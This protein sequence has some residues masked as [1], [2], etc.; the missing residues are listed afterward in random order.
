[1]TG[2]WIV[3]NKAVFV[4][5]LV[6]DYCQVSA[7]INEQ[8]R[9]FVTSGTVSYAVVRDLLGESMRKG[10]FWRLKDTAHYL[11]RAAAT[12]PESG[13]ISPTDDSISLW[14]FSSGK[15]PDGMVQQSAVEAALDWIIGYAFHECVKLKEDAFQHQHY[16]NRLLQMLRADQEDEESRADSPENSSIA[17]QINT[18][19]PPLLPL[20]RQTLT[21]IDRELTRILEVLEYGRSLLI[22]HLRQHCHNRHLARLLVTQEELIRSAFGPQ[23]EG[24]LTALYPDPDQRFVLTAHAYVEGGRYQEALDLLDNAPLR[25]ADSEEIR[26][27]RENI[28]QLTV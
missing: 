26:Q 2:N 13:G 6:R 4:R 17:G 19:F 7:A 12:S 8:S 23:Y 1:M 24:L 20:T 15:A 9:R 18:I 11:F 3:A 22:T 14:Q 28:Q 16:A 27:L 25:E 10:V 21:S 5:D